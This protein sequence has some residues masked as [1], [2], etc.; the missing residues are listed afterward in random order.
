MQKNIKNNIFEIKHKQY[1]FY[2]LQKFPFWGL[3]AFFMPNLY[4]IL[5]LTPQATDA[6]LKLA[7]KR[8][9]M[10]YHPDRNPNNPQSEEIFKQ[11]NEAYHILIN[12]DMRYSYDFYQK[13]PVFST[14]PPTP[15]YE[16]YTNSYDPANFISENQRK[17]I[18]KYTIYAVVVVVFLAV[19][20][21]YLMNKYTSKVHL[22]KA[23]ECLEAK[24]VPE[25]VRF[26]GMAIECDGYNYEARDFKG[27]I[28]TNVYSNH[29]KALE[30]YEFLV[31]NRGGADDYFS[32]GYCYLK[33]YQ[34][35]MAE[36]DFLEA[37]SKNEKKG[38][39]YHH[40]S[41]AQLA[42]KNPPKNNLDFCNN[43][44]KAL[45]LGVKDT[46]DVKNLQRNHCF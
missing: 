44:K 34:P 13:V 12:P 45:K 27:K 11:I 24:K 15:K 41:L 46:S 17:K 10:Q 9:A 23:K 32:R 38:D 35:E 8:L 26:V 37:I 4:E 21:G 3:G 7:Y 14:P 6:E 33:S 18:T 2:L 36:A 20:S 42:Q 31:K 30:E 25:A 29:F 43:L 40:L 16:P 19:I 1:I 5:G 28:Y 39:Y 22:E